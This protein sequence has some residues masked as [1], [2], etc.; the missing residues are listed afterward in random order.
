MNARGR[1][2]ALGPG[3]KFAGC[4]VCRFASFMTCSCLCRPRLVQITSPAGRASFK[5]DYTAGRYL[6]WREL[7][8]GSR[9]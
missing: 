2:T 5:T 6:P 8:K 1:P 7:S 9:L 4:L 3:L